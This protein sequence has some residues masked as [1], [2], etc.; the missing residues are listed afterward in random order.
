MREL[1]LVCTCGH[2]RKASRETFFFQGG[3]R[4]KIDQAAPTPGGTART[5][6]IRYNLEKILLLVQGET[7]LVVV[8]V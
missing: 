1:N 4:N 2:R 3:A 7:K 6:L 8:V 5:L